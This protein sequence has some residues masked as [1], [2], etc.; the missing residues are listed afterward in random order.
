MGAHSIERQGARSKH[1]RHLILSRLAAELKE[2]SRGSYLGSRCSKASA[3]P[4]R[5]IARVSNHRIA[6]IQL[7]HRV[8]HEHN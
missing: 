1:A 2:R 6:T 3:Q 5:R 7:R 8:A 4:R